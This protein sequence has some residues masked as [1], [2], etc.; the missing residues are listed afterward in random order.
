MPPGNKL[1]HNN[2]N[3]PH[4]GTLRKREHLSNLFW[5]FVQKCATFQEIS[6]RCDCVAFACQAKVYDFYQAQVIFVAYQDI[7]RFQI[8][9]E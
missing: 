6:Y 3:S 5:W 8:T 9:M 4:I 1:I 2:T 7:F